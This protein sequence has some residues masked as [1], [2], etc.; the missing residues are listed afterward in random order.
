MGRVL[1]AR[2]VERALAHSAEGIGLNV[3]AHNTP[4][5]ALYGRFGLSEKRAVRVIFRVEKKN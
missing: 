4:A 5:I 2:V 1:M 3:D